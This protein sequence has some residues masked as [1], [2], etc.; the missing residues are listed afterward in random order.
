M[1]TQ[2]KGRVEEMDV[3]KIPDKWPRVGGAVSVF[4]TT[5]IGT[6]DIFNPLS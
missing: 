5:Q 3:D 4:R 2:V 1:K 6:R